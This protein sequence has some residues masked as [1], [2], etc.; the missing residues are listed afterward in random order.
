MQ[1]INIINQSFLVDFLT[2]SIQN[3]ITGDSFETKIV[4]LEKEDIKKLIKSKNWLFDWG[5]EA[6][7]KG[8]NIYKLTLEDNLTIIQ[9]LI[10]ISILSDHVFMDL[11]ETAH[12][13]RNKNKMY[14]GVAGNLVA[15]ACK[16]SLELGFEGY[17]AFNA[18]TSLI[19]HYELTLGAVNSSGQKMMINPKESLK[20]INQYFQKP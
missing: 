15:F 14:L 10:S 19:K 17:I 4:L 13:N 5:K 3:R 11:L 18:K 20:L 8:R 12:F 16:L 6:K 1:I 9:G 7:T 2:N